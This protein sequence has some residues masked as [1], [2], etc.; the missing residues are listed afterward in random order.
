MLNFIAISHYRTLSDLNGQ[1]PFLYLEKDICDYMLDERE[2]YLLP[3]SPIWLSLFK[4]E[5]Y[6]LDFISDDVS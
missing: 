3:D 5:E 1:I 6:L 2:D 4:G